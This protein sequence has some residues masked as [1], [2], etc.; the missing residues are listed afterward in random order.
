MKHLLQL[1]TGIEGYARSLCG[2]REKLGGAGSCPNNLFRSTPPVKVVTTVDERRRNV[3]Y[4]R[5]NGKPAKA[6]WGK[7]RSLKKEKASGKGMR[8]NWGSKTLSGEVDER[9]TGRWKG[10]KY[11]LGGL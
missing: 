10:P 2:L 11:S 3:F 1:M 9:Q 4:K 5:K 6:P 7:A 8:S